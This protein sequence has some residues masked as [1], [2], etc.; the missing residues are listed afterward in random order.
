MATVYGSLA[1]AAYT[2]RNPFCHVQ[3]SVGVGALSGSQGRC[4]CSGQR[5]HICY[6]GYLERITKIRI[7]LKVLGGLT[8]SNPWSAYSLA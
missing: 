5:N 4:H 6:D 1:A 7:V 8:I 2:G 3:G